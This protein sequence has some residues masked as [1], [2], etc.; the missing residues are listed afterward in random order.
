MVPTREQLAATMRT[1][2]RHLL[3]AKLA[4]GELTEIAEGVATD[5]LKRR[6]Q[7]GEPVVEQEPAG[8]DARRSMEDFTGWSLTAWSIA[9]AIALFV[10]VAFGTT[11]RNKG[12]QSFLYGVILTQAALL[13]GLFRVVASVFSSE[14]SL[15]TLG[16]ILVVGAICFALFILTMCSVMSQ[17]GWKGG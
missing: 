3:E 15:G 8:T 5:E 2:P 7:E 9:F 6:E 4:S 11:A 16:K 10:V 13:A 1:L 14:S 17:S 12:D